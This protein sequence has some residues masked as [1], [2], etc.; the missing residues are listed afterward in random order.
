M[1]C[2]VQ[3]MFEIAHFRQFFAVFGDLL[4]PFTNQYLT[5]WSPKCFAVVSINLFERNWCEMIC[6]I[7]YLFLGSQNPRCWSI[8][9]FAWRIFAVFRV[10]FAIFIYGNYR[11]VYFQNPLI[12]LQLL[13]CDNHIL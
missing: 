12:I 13:I 7:L 6:H 11:D 3:N 1:A 2:Y 5:L 4:S 9:R 8:F 10:Y